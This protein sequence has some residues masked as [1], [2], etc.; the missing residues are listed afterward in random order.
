MRVFITGA[1]GY[2]GNAVASAFR[3]KAHSVYGLVRTDIDANQLRKKEIIPV[4]GDMAEPATYQQ[5]LQEVEVVVHCAFDIQEN[6]GVEHDANTIQNILQELSKSKLPRSFIYTSGCWVYGSAGNKIVDE[7]MD[8]HPIDLV[9]WRPGHEEK[10]LQANSPSLRTVV[11]RPGHVFGNSGG[12]TQLLFNATQMG[13]IPLIGTGDNRWPMVHVQDLA[14][15]YVAAAEKELSGVVLN[16]VDDSTLTAR[17]ICEAMTNAAKMEGKIQQI[18]LEEGKQ[19]FGGLA[20]GLAIDLRLSNSR[21]KR[22]L[23]WH[24]HHAPFIYDVDLYY[25]AWKATQQ[26]EEF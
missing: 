2:I 4:I 3:S 8:L 18:S 1:S 6:K 15:A 10:V 12:I 23:G 11:L 17:E 24:I 21:I 13:A 25:Q 14:Y 16:V 20:D 26:I 22:L 5:V 7:S 19:Q 9:Q